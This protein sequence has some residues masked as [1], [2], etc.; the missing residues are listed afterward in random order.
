[1]SA[2]NLQVYA[3]MYPKTGAMN[4]QLTRY[5]VIAHGCY[6]FTAIHS[7]VLANGCYQFAVIYNNVFANGCD[8]SAV[9]PLQYL[10]NWVPSIACCQQ[11]GIAYGCYKLA[12]RLYAA[13]C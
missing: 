11:E 1:M 13:L 8:E 9:Y 7:N 6:R 10:S 12:V 3:A 4:L 5:L 2:I